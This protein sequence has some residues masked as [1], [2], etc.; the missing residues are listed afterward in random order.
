M[1]DRKRVNISI[2]PTTYAKLQRLVKE[3]KFKN[4]CELLVSMAHILLDRIEDA[5]LKK[6]ELP[7]EDAAYIG[8]MFEELGHVERVP[9]GNAPVTHRRESIK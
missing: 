9:D 8:Q 1:S 6:Y 5:S 7:E 4:L 2:D 3:Y